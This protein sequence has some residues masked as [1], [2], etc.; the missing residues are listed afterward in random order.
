MMRRAIL[1]AARLFT[2]TNASHTSARL[3]SRSGTPAP[4][5]GWSFLASAELYDPT[6]AFASAKAMTVARESHAAVR[7]RDG[8]V[9]VVGGHRGR[10]ADIT[11]YASAETYD[12]TTDTFSRVGDMRIRRHKHDAVL[13]G[14]G[15]VLVTGGYGNRQGPQAS[16]WVYRP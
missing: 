5:R 8:R 15:R 7:L 3:S 9:L 1:L 11:L 13:L 10:R 4:G 16:A 6:G 14:D 12:P 2:F